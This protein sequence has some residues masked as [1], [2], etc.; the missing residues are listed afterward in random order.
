MLKTGRLN[1]K[2]L[3]LKSLQHT[4]K[5]A[6]DNPLTQ[7]NLEQGKHWENVHKPSGISQVIFEFEDTEIKDKNQDQAYLLGRAGQPSK[8]SLNKC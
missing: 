4:S 7:N 1:I 3:H 2:S 5:Y 6:H 8:H